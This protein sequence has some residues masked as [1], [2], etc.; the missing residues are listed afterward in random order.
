MNAK[1]TDCS[2][3]LG[4]SGRRAEYRSARRPSHLPPRG[5]RAY[6][7]SGAVVAVVVRERGGV[8]D[9]RPLLASRPSLTLQTVKLTKNVLQPHT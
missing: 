8:A 9:A 4:H 3:G 7:F 6:I 5:R 2:V 1:I